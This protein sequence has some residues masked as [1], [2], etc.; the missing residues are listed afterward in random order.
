MLRAEVRDTDRTG[1]PF[2]QHLLGR[3]VRGHGPVEVARHRVVQQEEVDVV[4]AES[5]QATLE[6]AQRW[7]V[8]VVAD[9]QLRRHEHLAALDSGAA[10]ALADLA[11]VHVGG[12]GVDQ[13]VAV[14]DRRLDRADRFG[15]RALEDAEAEG[16]HLDA[17][18]HLDH[19]G[20]R[21]R[22]LC[23]P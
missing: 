2:R 20:C 16:G 9:P 7:L 11:L 18:G 8:A 6:A 5:P 4:E 10:D 22:H 23:S 1:A 17:V 3:L 13:P 15:G 19:R 12:R 14:L 21:C